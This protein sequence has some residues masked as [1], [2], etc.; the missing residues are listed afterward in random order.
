MEL[1]YYTAHYY[2]YIM[3]MAPLYWTAKIDLRVVLNSI[4]C[5]QDISKISGRTDI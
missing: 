4:R 2:R 1:V 3:F 5:I